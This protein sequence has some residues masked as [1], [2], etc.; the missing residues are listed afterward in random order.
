MR[1]NMGQ[2]VQDY[3]KRIARNLWDIRQN[4]RAIIKM[5][6]WAGIIGAVVSGALIALWH[7]VL[8]KI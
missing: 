5:S 6:A 2:V 1:Q 7:W 3:D 8:R 4:E